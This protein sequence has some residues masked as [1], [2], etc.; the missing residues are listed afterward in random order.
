MEYI[1]INKDKLKKLIEEN[2]L[3]FLDF[4]ECSY[5]KDCKSQDCTNC[6][7]DYLQNE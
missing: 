4:K 5:G 6:I 1:E 7:I 3:F 2:L